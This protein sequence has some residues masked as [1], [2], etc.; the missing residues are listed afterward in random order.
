LTGG[1]QDYIIRR[2]PPTAA[3]TEEAKKAICLLP[4]TNIGGSNI[5]YSAIINPNVPS[6]IS[7]NGLQT[8]D[9]SH[10]IRGLLRRYKLRCLGQ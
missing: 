10:H 3:L 7:I 2:T 6:G 4:G 5:P 8:I 9:Y 1:L